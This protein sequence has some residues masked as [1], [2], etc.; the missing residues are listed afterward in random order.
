M[1]ETYF[2]RG[3][4]IAPDNPDLYSNVGTV[5]FFLG[6]FEEDAQYIQKAIALQPQRY[7]YWGNLADAYRSNTGSAPSR[8]LLLH[9]DGGRS[10]AAAWCAQSTAPPYTAGRCVSRSRS[11]QFTR[12]CV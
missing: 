2:R 9:A 7:E 11:N 5:S 3:L 12:E 4:Q 10:S 1:A 8:S 6:H